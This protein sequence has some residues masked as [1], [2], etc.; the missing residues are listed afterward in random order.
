MFVHLI[1]WWPI[2][3]A[4]VVKN[5]SDVISCLFSEIGKQARMEDWEMGKLKNDGGAVAEKS[6]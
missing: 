4:G 6:Y 5:A 1:E 2:K 3:V